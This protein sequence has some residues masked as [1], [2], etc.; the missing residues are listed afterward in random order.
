MLSALDVRPA[1]ADHRQ[2]YGAPVE[3]ILP[4][5]VSVANVACIVACTVRMH[6][7][8]GELGIAYSFTPRHMSASNGCAPHA[9][10]A[11]GLRALHAPP[12]PTLDDVRSLATT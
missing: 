2:A 9:P 12:R 11:N 1:L 6:R 4:R 5:Q 3:A 10:R 7:A 8:I